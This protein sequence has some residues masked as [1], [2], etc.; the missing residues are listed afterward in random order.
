V[1]GGTVLSRTFHRAS[2]FQIVNSPCELIFPYRNGSPDGK[3]LYAPPARNLADFLLRVQGAQL[4]MIL[5][6]R[7]S[8]RGKFEANPLRRKISHGSGG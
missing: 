6:L 1:I 7:S 3:R 2:A 4:G 8:E 5:T